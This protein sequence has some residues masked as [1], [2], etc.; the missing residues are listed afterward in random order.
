M[1]ISRGKFAKVIYKLYDA[2][3]QRLLEAVPKAKPLVLRFGMGHLFPDFEKNLMG[4]EAGDRFDF[5]IQ[6]ERAY[7]PVDTYAIFDVSKDTFESQGELPA[8][9]FQPGRRVSMHDNNGMRH[10]GKMIKIM[11]DAV[12]IDFNHPLAGKD[13]RYVGEVLEVFDQPEVHKKQ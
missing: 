4:L 10:V 7:G 3:D 6:A 2:K 5:V 8:D 11:E 1:Q 9:F 13:L 12:T